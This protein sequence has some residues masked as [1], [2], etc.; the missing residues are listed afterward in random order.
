MATSCPQAEEFAVQSIAQLYFQEPDE[1]SLASLTLLCGPG[2][3]DYRQ[4]VVVSCIG[5][6]GNLP[7]GA[8]I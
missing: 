2:H 3:S 5:G 6:H 4:L 1:Q 8:V 7:P